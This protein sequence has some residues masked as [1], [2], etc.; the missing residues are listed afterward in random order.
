MAYRSNPQA[1]A[2]HLDKAIG[3]VLK[4]ADPATIAFLALAKAHE[5]GGAVIGR[6]A[7]WWREHKPRKAKD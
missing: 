6:R 1:F 4:G 3:Y 5:S 7:G 2:Y